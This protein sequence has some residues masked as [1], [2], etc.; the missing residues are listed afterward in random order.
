M[1]RLVIVVDDVRDWGPYYPSHSVISFDDYLCLGTT[2]ERVRV[3]NLCRN[4]RYLGSGYYCSLLAEARGHHVIPSLKTLTELSAKPLSSIQWQGM[5]PTLAALAPGQAGE[6]KQLRC[7]F[8]ETLEPEYADLA[9]SA[10]QHFPCPILELRMVYRQ[11]WRMDK[12]QAASL[13]ALSSSTEQDSFAACFER[14]SQKLWRPAPAQ[15]R[16]RYDLAIL[17]DTEEAMPPSDGAALRKFIR[18]AE[19]YGICAEL[20]GRADYSRLAEYDGLFIRTTTSVANISYRFAKRAEA[21]GLVVIDDSQSILRCTNKIYLADLLRRNAVA[22][23]KTEYLRSG[24]ESEARRLIDALGLPLV[25]KVP[26]GAFSKGVVKVDSLAALCAEAQ[27]LLDKSAL[28]LAQEFMYTEY[29]WRIGVLDGQ[30]LF[31]CRYYMVKKHWQIYRHGK[32]SQSGGFDAV[33]ISDV[34]ADVLRAAVSACQLI[35]N[36]FYGVDIKQQGSRVVV[37]E[38]NDNPSIDS[39]VEDKLL[40]DS[41]YAAVIEVFLRRMERRGLAATK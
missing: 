6:V 15:K 33:P 32:R 25:L 30:P 20:I 10:F 11:G 37:I 12:L 24:S 4:Y 22:V 7:W 39:G 1:S 9:R 19:K 28:L 40:G 2:R 36:S 18:V 16:F 26:D 41:L 14:F 23:P 8:G 34:P 13:R 5:L 21:E 35:G 27:R 17:V 3:V 29:D 31:A 38:V